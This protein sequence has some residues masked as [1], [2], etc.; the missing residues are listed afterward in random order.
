MSHQSGSSLGAI[1]VQL[2][3]S[4]SAGELF[5]T[6]SYSKSYDIGRTGMADPE[7][8]DEATR[9]H[10]T[11]MPD[12]SDSLSGA[13][14]FLSLWMHVTDSAIPPHKRDEVGMP[15]GVMLLDAE[16]LAAWGEMRLQVTVDVIGDGKGKID[17]QLVPVA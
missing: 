14:G 16:G 11:N 8:V 7:R 13:G 9:D 17:L 4:A 10:I 15:D 12:L 1:I 6:V 3:E 5:G 2:P